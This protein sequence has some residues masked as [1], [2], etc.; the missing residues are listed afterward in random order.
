[1]RSPKAGSIAADRY[2]RIFRLVGEGEL[3]IQWSPVAF[4]LALLICGIDLVFD[5]DCKSKC[6]RKNHYVWPA[7]GVRKLSPDVDEVRTSRHSLK[8]P[9]ESLQCGMT[10]GQE[11]A[12][13]EKPL[14]VTSSWIQEMGQD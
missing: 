13:E 1:M 11:F 3:R 8:N 9:W 5:G 12:Q 10:I 6:I 7:K 4:E 14:S 2:R